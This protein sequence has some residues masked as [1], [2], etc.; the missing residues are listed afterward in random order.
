MRSQLPPALFIGCNFLSNKVIEIRMCFW[1][2][3]YEFFVL[4]DYYDINIDFIDMIKST[5]KQENN[6]KKTTTTTTNRSPRCISQNLNT[7]NCFYTKY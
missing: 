5:T 3:L 7:H 6:N 1:V 4:H 2:Q